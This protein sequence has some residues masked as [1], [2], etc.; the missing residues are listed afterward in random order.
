MKAREAIYIGN[1]IL[2]HDKSDFCVRLMILP[3]R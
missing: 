1:R 3:G 2:A